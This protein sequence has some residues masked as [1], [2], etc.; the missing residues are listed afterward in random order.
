MWFR[1]WRTAHRERL[2]ASLAEGGAL[3]P[4]AAEREELPRDAEI[5]G[6]WGAGGGA[7]HT[8]YGY[9]HEDQVRDERP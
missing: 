9:E 1:K 5:E 2:L 6:G 8:V 7:R 3:P 4:S